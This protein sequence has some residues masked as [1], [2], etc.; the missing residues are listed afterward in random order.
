MTEKKFPV[1]GFREG[2]LINLGEGNW[3]D[4]VRCLIAQID[5]RGDFYKGAKLAIDVN[6]QNIRAADM[7]ALRDLLSDRGI[8]LFAILGKSSATQAVAESLGLATTKSVLR[9]NRDGF[10]HALFDGEKAIVIQKTLR[11]GALVKFPGSVV[12]DGD[13]NP[14]AQV[15]AAG[16]I[17]VWGKLR[18]SVHAGTDGSTEEVVCALD[19]NPMRMRIANIEKE[20]P[21]LKIK[22]KR[23]LC[24]AKVVDGSIKLVEW[25][26]ER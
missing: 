15:E 22:M 19:F 6:E 12:V 25:V 13:V 9:E 16:S 3:A 4:L 14:G 17:Y 24:K 23:T 11:S 18:G 20:A 10:S 26:S 2:L 8:T 1:K 5:E 7:G 21:K